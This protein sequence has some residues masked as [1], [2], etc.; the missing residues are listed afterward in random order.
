ML[1]FQKSDLVILKSD[2]QELKNCMVITEINEILDFATVIYT[3]AKVGKIT[4]NIA[5]CALVHYQPKE[6]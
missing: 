1:K 2:S 5:L 6:E 4:K 3:N